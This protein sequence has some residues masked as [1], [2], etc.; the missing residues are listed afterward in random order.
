[1]LSVNKYLKSKY[2]IQP[3]ILLQATVKICEKIN[4]LYIKNRIKDNI[5]NQ[6]IFQLLVNDLML[7]CRYLGLFKI[8]KV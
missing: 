5:E 8:D 2:N 4:Q 7:A 6:K 1:M 3:N